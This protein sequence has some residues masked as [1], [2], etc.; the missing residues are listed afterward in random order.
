MFLP[1]ITVFAI[2]ISSYFFKQLQATLSKCIVQQW[3][4]EMTILTSRHFNN[5]SCSCMPTNTE[6]LHYCAHGK[7]YMFHTMDK[8]FWALVLS[9]HLWY[10]TEEINGRN[11]PSKIIIFLFRFF[12]KSQ[13]LIHFYDVVHI[14]NEMVC[15]GKVPVFLNVDGHYWH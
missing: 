9:L 3:A 13:Y 15:K 4:I 10:S 5:Y 7:R 12:F 6:A 8:Q 14:F 2:K 1:P 11:R